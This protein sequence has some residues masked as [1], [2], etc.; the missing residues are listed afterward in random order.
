MKADRLAD[1]VYQPA[2]SAM[3]MESGEVAALPT[4]SHRATGIYQSTARPCQL[5][6]STTKKMSA[7]TG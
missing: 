7:L 5:A 6:V 2:E 1:A 3:A 4:H